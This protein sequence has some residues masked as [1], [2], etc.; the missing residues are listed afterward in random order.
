VVNNSI[1]VRIGIIEHTHTVIA[2][3]PSIVFNAELKIRSFDNMILDKTIYVESDIYHKR[4]IKDLLDYIR[5]EK[6]NFLNWQF[7]INEQLQLRGCSYEKFGKMSGFS[8]NTIKTWCCN[9]TMPRSRDMFIKLAF[10]LKMNIDETNELLVKYGKYSALYAKDLYDAITI[11][12]INQR[13]NNWDDENY[14]YDSLEKWYKKFEKITEEHQVNPK[15]YNDPK[16]IGIFNEIENIK[17][18]STFEKYVLDN[19]EIFFSTYSS[20]ICF[21]EDFIEIRLSEKSDDIAEEKYSWH[22]YV[23]DKGLDSS[24][25]IML[26]RL[27]HNG[28]LPKREQLIALGIHLNMVANDI[29]KMLS[30]ANMRELYARDMAESL[31]MYL[32]RNAEIADPDLQFNNAWKYVMT[33]SDKKIKK[34]YQDIIERYYG[35]DYDEEWSDDGIEDLSEYIKSMIN[36]NGINEKLSY[37]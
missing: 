10:G 11:Y 32:L 36:D 31:I 12:V 30:L 14:N 33:A 3:F 15:Y 5:Q 26:S 34:E 13:I 8:K 4:S 17:D 6:D 24:F 23:T 18:D 16:T 27:K 29:N 9:G 25:E 22:K 20:L 7:Y 1:V 19:K 28:V 37:L 21:I 2:V 35:E